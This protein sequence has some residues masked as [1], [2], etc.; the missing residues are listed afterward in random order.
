[1]AKKEDDVP[2][3]TKYHQHTF[4]KLMTRAQAQRWG[5]R[6]MSAGLKRAGFQ[7]VV[8][9]TSMDLHGWEGYRINYGAK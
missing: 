6:N 3:V 1:M 5:E 7:V 4:D 2:L 9:K 8:C